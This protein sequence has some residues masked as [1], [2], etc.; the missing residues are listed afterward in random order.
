VQFLSDPAAYREHTHGVETRETHMSWV[1]LTDAEAWKLKKPVHFSYLDFS[2]ID[3]RHRDAER[4]L[5]LNR[6]LAPDVYRE[7]VPLTVAADG[8]LALGG[9]GA[10]CDWLVRMRRLDEDRMLDARIARGALRSAE[11]DALVAVLAAF[12]RG[13]PAVEIGPEEY[14]Q[15]FLREIRELDRELTAPRFGQDAGQVERILAGLRGFLERRRELLERRVAA[16]RIVE[17]HGDLR[18]E[19]V[20]LEDPPRVIDCLQFKRAFRL[21][22]P[23]AE[24]AFLGME[25][26]RLDADWAGR[27]LMAGYR[28]RAG[29]P[30]PE[31]LAAFHRTHSACL[32]AKL[33]VWHLN[34]GAQDAQ[35]WV[36]RA[37]RY[38]GLAEAGL[39]GL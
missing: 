39:P 25:C 1:F 11:L 30:V 19:H 36:R 33:S 37:R 14:R 3:A 13:A 34:D 18:P 31:P 22:D 7:V 6:R 27:R 29:D 23:A 15:R 17:G 16:G 9:A 10:A 32:R 28:E 21:Q 4:E 26:T 5:R 38:L 12:Y 8:S 20:C 2:T 24:L 35:K